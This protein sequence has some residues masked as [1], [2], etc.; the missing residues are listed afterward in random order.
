M[1]EEK[2][3]L[4]CRVGARVVTLIP[5]L[6]STPSSRKALQWHRHLR[7]SVVASLRVRMHPQHRCC[8]P[9]LDCLALGIPLIITVRLFHKRIPRLCMLNTIFS[10]CIWVRIELTHNLFYFI[11]WRSWQP[12][13]SQKS[14]TL[15]STKDRNMMNRN[16][17]MGNVMQNNLLDA[18]S[19]DNT[20]RSV[21][22]YEWKMY[23]FKAI[24][25]SID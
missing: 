19:F 23:L 7:E 5:L 13:T 25:G 1:T 9:S 15:N 12:R 20:S 6:P 14:R 22:L 2:N 16:C 3:H 17:G 18:S 8:S 4:K 21:L 10:Q 11:D 24:I